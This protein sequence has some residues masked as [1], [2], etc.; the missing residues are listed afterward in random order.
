VHIEEVHNL[1][2]SSVAIVAIKA[3]RIRWAGRAVRMVE[4]RK[5]VEHFGRGAET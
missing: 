4:M 2:A 3:R 1:N 5:C